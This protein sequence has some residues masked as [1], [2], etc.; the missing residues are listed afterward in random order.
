MADTNY[1]RDVIKTISNELI[2][3]IPVV[4]TAL[5]ATTSLLVGWYT[6]RQKEKRWND[7]SK[8]MSA[9]VKRQVEEAK[10]DA[11]EKELRGFDENLDGLLRDYERLRGDSEAKREIQGRLSALIDRVRA[12]QPKVYE[13]EIYVYATAPFLEHYFLVYL[14]ALVTGDM[15]GIRSY[16]FTALRAQLY[17]DTKEYVSAAMNGIAAERAEDIDTFW[18]SIGLTNRD[19]RKQ[20]DLSS[21]Y[22]HRDK[23]RLVPC[24]QHAAAVVAAAQLM[25]IP[26]VN[27]SKVV[28]ADLQAG[29]LPATGG[30]HP[31]MFRNVYSAEIRALHA[32]LQKVW[33]YDTGWTHVI[34]G[35]DNQKTTVKWAEVWG[36][37]Y[38]DHGRVA[39]LAWRDKHADYA[40][41]VFNTI[42]DIP[43]GRDTPSKTKVDLPPR[44]ALKADNGLYLSRVREGNQDYLRPT[45]QSI[46]SACMF[47]TRK[48]GEDRYAFQADNETWLGIVNNGGRYSLLP[49]KSSPSDPWALFDVD[50]FEDGLVAVRC[51][52]NTKYWQRVYRSPSEHTIDA[53]ADA[54]VRPENRFTYVAC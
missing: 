32:R 31:D 48:M 13:D 14:T 46:D 20:I 12:F 29:G 39:D 18:E 28:A 16:D 26:V 50:I 19:L 35:A 1:G 52:G 9:Y 10:T 3:A 51:V 25:R 30:I 4:G 44:V 24:S 7:I 41:R 15:I 38:A 2:G 21:N 42:F 53:S 54:A 27:I 8:A 45:K 17:L 47:A 11:I 23:D 36:M 6:D 37:L 33:E 34:T 49:A 5:S 40:N 22:N 43:G